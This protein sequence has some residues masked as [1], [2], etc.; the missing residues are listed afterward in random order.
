MNRELKKEDAISFFSELF[1]GEHHIPSE[2]KNC[3]NGWSVKSDRSDMA[4]TDLIILLDLFL[5]VMNIA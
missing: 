5:C 4:T 3:G 1:Y 2:L